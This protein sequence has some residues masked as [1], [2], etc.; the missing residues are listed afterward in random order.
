MT[1]TAAHAVRTLPWSTGKARPR[2]TPPCGL[3][4]GGPCRGRITGFVPFAELKSADVAVAPGVYVVLYLGAEPPVF[5]DS[6]PVGWRKDKDP[7]VDVERLVRSWVLGAEVLYIGKA[8]AKASAQGGLRKRLD[9]YRRHGAGDRIGHWG[10][11]SIW[12]LRDSHRLVVAWKATA[13]DPEDAEAD[14]LDDF[15]RTYGQRFFANLK[16][17]RRRRA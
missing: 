7:S 6:S 5:L 4:A 9:E 17:G 14:S 3:D 15:V 10:G 11:R 13:N 8:S 16:A 12:Q 1:P 2:D